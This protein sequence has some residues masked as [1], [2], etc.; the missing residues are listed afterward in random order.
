MIKYWVEWV[1]H[2]TNDKHSTDLYDTQE[3]AMKAVPT[4]RA[5]NGSIQ[6][7]LVAKYDEPMPW[8]ETL[9]EHEQERV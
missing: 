7:Y 4:W 9:E 1:D 6:V 3:E 8:E 5:Y 2:G